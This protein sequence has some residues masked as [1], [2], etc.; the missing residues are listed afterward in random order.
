MV[1]DALTKV[2]FLVPDP[3]TVLARFDAWALRI[4]PDGGMSWMGEAR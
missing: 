1:A 2:V 4:T 3:V